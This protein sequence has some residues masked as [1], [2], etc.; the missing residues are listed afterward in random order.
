M[1]GSVMYRIFTRNWWKH[2]SDWPDGREPDGGAPKHN[3]GKAETE[4]EAISICQEWNRT[5]K[6]GKLSRKAEFEDIT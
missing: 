1:G 6:P 2:N 3:I 5:H 4:R